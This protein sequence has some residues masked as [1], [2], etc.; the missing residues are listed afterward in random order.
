MIPYTRKRAM[1]NGLL[2]IIDA[3]IGRF[4]PAVGETLAK[5]HSVTN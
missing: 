4:R 1:L 5:P 2:A 3:I